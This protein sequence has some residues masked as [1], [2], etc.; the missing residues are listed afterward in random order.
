MPV[1]RETK[2]SE[3]QGNAD[4]G[5]TP[6]SQDK[7]FREI[8]SRLGQDAFFEVEIAEDSMSVTAT[9]F[10]PRGKGKPLTRG[11][12][13]TELLARG[14]VKGVE[15]E[16]IEGALELC[17]LDRKTL[18]GVKI[19]QGKAP[20]PAAEAHIVLEAAFAEPKNKLD[21]G[22]ATKIDY[23]VISPFIMIHKDDVVGHMEPARPGE[24][25]YTVRGDPLPFGKQ[26]GQILEMGERLRQVGADIVSCADGRFAVANGKRLTVEEVLEIKGMVDYHTGH[27]AFPGNII[28]DSGIDVGFKVYSGAS[29]MCKQ[30]IDA[31]DIN[32]KK[33]LVVQGGIIGKQAAH[34]RVGGRLE[35]K[36]IENCKVAVR[37][38]VTVSG[39][40]VNSRLYTLGKLD[41]GD[42]GRIAGGEI[43]AAKGVRAARIGVATG[44][45]LSIHCGVDF[46][47]QQKVDFIKE[48]LRILVAKGLKADELLKRKP[49]PSLEA[50]RREIA[51]MQKQLLESL[52]D[53]ET[54][55][56]SEPDASIEVKDEIFPGVT[57]SICR[58]SIVVDKSLKLTRF[59]IDHQ[60]GHIVSEPL[61]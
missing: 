51:A 55:L 35:A 15:W 46:T 6:S 19:A 42:K 16:A 50:I 14:I 37:G 41:L 26:A 45:A 10:P 48:R 25:G 11:D 60:A 56:D 43:W 57:I 44:Q 23:K 36:F 32:A 12:V 1:D 22:A 5:Q 59:K 28:L 31:S 8:N 9:F 53:F 2:K 49:T 34:V 58:F 54:K 24:E 17:N 38:D 40:V 27:I 30:T 61:R 18:H 52:A 21:P 13:E 20:V 7:G 33:D 39:A 47:M 3:P 29:I 4:S